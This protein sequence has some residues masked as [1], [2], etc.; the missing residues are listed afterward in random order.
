MAP[1]GYQ[2]VNFLGKK[3]LEPLEI[4]EFG[5]GHDTARQRF[6]TNLSFIDYDQLAHKNTLRKHKLDHMQQLLFD[7]QT[8]QDKFLTRDIVRR[9]SMQFPIYSQTDGQCKLRTP[10]DIIY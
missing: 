6:L 9:Q 7:N 8:Q 4:D 5:A 3:F 2:I 1:P 10:G